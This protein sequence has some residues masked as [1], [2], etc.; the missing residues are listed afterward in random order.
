MDKIRGAMA[1]ITCAIEEIEAVKA[2]NFNPFEYPAYFIERF[3][4]LIDLSK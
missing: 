1:A 2:N 3:P 4:Q